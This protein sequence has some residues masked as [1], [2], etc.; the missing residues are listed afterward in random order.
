[1]T[2]TETRAPVSAAAAEPGRS[3][4]T[5]APA[6]LPPGS[7]L[8]HIGPSKT[9]TTSLQAAMWEARAAMRDQGVHY[10]GATRHSS[11]AARAGAGIRDFY[12]DDDTPP[13][14]WHW[15]GIVREFRSAG[16]HRVILSSE[17][18]AHARPAAIR[19]MV[20]ELDPGRV[21]V[22][23]TL[24]PIARM[25][26]SLWQQRIQSGSPRTFTEWLEANL[27]REGE[28]AHRSIW[29]QHRHGRLVARWAEVVGRDRVTVVVV[30]SS[31]H[32]W[33][34]RA[35]EGLL[36][37]RPG[38]LRLQDDYAN[39]SLTLGEARAVRI[40]NLQLRAA[41]LG[42]TDLLHIVHNGAARYLKLR[43]PAPGEAKIR[44]PAW[45]GERAAMLA[46]AAVGEIEASGVRVL[47]DL[48][49]L[50]SQPELVPEE[51][52]DD[53]LVPAE[54]A[55]SMAMGVAYTAGM[56]RNSTLAAQH[57]RLAQSNELS[58]LTTRDLVRL[59]ADR[60]R[61]FGP[62]II[63]QRLGRQG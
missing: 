61:R 31:D 47:G 16:D 15:K 39:R 24:R 56:M 5:D 51:D 30:D 36:G 40:L 26:T 7:R 37:L 43:T 21:H 55:A 29:H 25:L 48:A 63:R 1:M 45:A 33:L 17:F 53:G 62:R 27:G 3:A 54:I 12:G 23:V 38:T 50:R 44:L 35:F 19:S 46:D 6:A 28:I 8:L 2:T 42:R 11:L 22:V 60:V 57:E 59:Q 20:E 9:G 58:Y 52:P 14:D 4:S 18:L 34:L 32:G 10:A 41:G 49:S 13:P